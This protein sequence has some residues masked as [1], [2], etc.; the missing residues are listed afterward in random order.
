[1]H[2][3]TL[4]FSLLS[5][6]VHSLNLLPR[7]IQ[8]LRGTKGGADVRLHPV[9]DIPYASI[10][11][12]LDAI[13]RRG[14]IYRGPHWIIKGPQGGLHWCVQ[15]QLGAWPMVASDTYVSIVSSEIGGAARNQM[16]HLGPGVWPVEGVK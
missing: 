3:K 11:L 1:V 14:D 2:A 9:D 8:L 6:L 12:T 5:E 16:I 15:D 10:G 13:L 4:G 7:A